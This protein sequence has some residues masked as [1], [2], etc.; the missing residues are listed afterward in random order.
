MKV[1][2]GPILDSEIDRAKCSRASNSVGGEPA[3]ISTGILMI[4]LDSTGC[5]WPLC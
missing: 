2:I 4:D 3:V 1:D 5:G